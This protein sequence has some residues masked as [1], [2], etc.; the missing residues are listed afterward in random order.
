MRSWALQT[1]HTPRPQ[2]GGAKGGGTPLNKNIAP[3]NC[4][5]C[6]LK[7]PFF[8]RQFEDGGCVFLKPTENWEKSRPIWQDDFFFF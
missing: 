8:L 1:R 3:L 4:P 6:P 5:A 2:L 7:L